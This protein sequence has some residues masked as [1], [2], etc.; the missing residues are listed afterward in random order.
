M[1]APEAALRQGLLYKGYTIQ[2]TRPRRNGSLDPR[3]EPAG[4]YRDVKDT[5]CTSQFRVIA[6]RRARNSSKESKVNSISGWTTTPWTLPSNTALA[7]GP[8]IEYVKVKCRNPTPTGADGH[9]GQE[10]LG[11]YFT[12]KMEG[13][14]EIMEGAGKVPSWKASATSS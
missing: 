9:S 8:A 4:C 5:T 3:T 13:T 7:V 2:P 12:K 11:S 14:Y 1:V 10:L 6:T